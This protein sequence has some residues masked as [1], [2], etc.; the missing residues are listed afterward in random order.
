MPLERNQ[1][2]GFCTVDAVTN[3]E[4]QLLAQLPLGIVFGQSLVC[5]GHDDAESPRQVVLAMLGNSIHD[6]LDRELTTLHTS[7]R[8]PVSCSGGTPSGWLC[9]R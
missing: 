3:V 4:G 2:N 1:L 8:S 9:W 6:L 5:H 7:D